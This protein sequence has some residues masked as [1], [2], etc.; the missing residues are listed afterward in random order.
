MRLSFTFVLLLLLSVGAASQA[1]NA[2]ALDSVPKKKL[3]HILLFDF[4]YGVQLPAADMAKDFK[5]NFNFGGRINLYFPSNWWGAVTGD[6][7]FFDDVKT[8]VVAPLRNVDGFIITSTG[9]LGNVHL[10]QR[11]MLL[12]GMVGKLVP[13]APKKNPRMGIDFGLGADYFQHWIRIRVLT[14]DIVQ[15]SGDY[16]KGYDRM[17]SGFALQEY[18]GFRYMGKKKLLNISAG[19]DF[20]QGFTKNRRPMN[21]DTRQSDTKQHIDLLFGFRVGLSLPIYIHSQQSLRDDPIDWQ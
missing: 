19:F 2:T 10:G 20:V 12:G 1:K 21:F 3:P 7:Q 11:G 9:G 6:F 14:E 15:L 16:K 13:F 4:M 5:L 17:T 18:I 8:D